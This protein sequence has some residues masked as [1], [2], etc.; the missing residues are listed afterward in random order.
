MKKHLLILIGISTLALTGILFPLQIQNSFA[1]TNHIVIS[2]IQIAGD[3]SNN[4]F[5]ELYNPTSVDINLG[6]MKLVKRTGPSSTDDSIEAFT[7]TDIIPAHGFYLW[8]NTSLEEILECDDVSTNTISNNNSI[9]LRY[10]PS[11]T[12]VLIDSVTFGTPDY[13]LGES[14]FLIAPDTLISVERKAKIDS[15]ANS[16]QSGGIDEF[17]GNGHDSDNNSSDFINRSTPQ[18]QN[19]NSDKEPALTSPTPTIEPST[20]PE[21]SAEPSPTVTPTTEPSP[22]LT[23]EPSPTPTVEPTPTTEPTVT[24]TPTNGPKIF[25]SN[26]IITCTVTYKGMHIFGRTFYFPLVRCART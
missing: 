9:G 1:A 5:I 2:E 11:D 26:P 24:P 4:D 16:M 12:G 13:P 17:E 7:N 8:C 15:T 14:S 21:P 19:S 6:D 3:S 23:P 25:N 22:T 20:S 10:E 18:P